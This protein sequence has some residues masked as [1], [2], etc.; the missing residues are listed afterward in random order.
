[1]DSGFPG[2]TSLLVSVG[3]ALQAGQR[4]S[5]VVWGNGKRTHTTHILSFNTALVKNSIGVK[6]VGKAANDDTTYM[7]C[8]IFM[9]SFSAET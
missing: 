5:G 3:C 7:F 1:M 2:N 6:S 8:S 4:L 9:V